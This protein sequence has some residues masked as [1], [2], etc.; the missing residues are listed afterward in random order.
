MRPTARCMHIG[1]LSDPNNFHTQKWARGLHQAG[2]EV[3]VF[4]F[5]PFSGDQLRHVRIDPPQAWRGRYTYLSYLRGGT[6]LAD[7][8]SEAGV[9]LL[10]PLNVTPF[11]VWAMQ[12]NFHPVVTCAFG[13]D[14]LEYPPAME[15]SP[16]LRHRS[17][18]NVEGGSSWLRRRKESVMRKFY[19]RQVRRALDYSD[20]VTGD[21]RYLVDRM[22]EWF[23]VPR[24]KLQLLRWGVEPELF[25]A[26]AR[27]LEA[28]RKKFGI[29]KDARVVLSPRG[30]KSI[31]QADIILAAFEQLITSGPA[32]VHYILLSAGYEVSERLR[33][34]AQ[35]LQQRSNRFVF[36]EEAVPREEIHTL[37]NLVDLFITA[38]VY[39]GYS[40]ALAEGRYAGAVPVV[41]AI[42]ANTELITHDHNGWIC[43]PFTA[44]QLAADLSHLLLHLHEFKE[45]Y[46]T[47]NRTWME[48][49]SLMHQNCGRFIEICKPLIPNG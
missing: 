46:Q 35:A 24:E 47:I 42:P 20:L 11:G 23:G 30:A 14:I 32:D 31:Y 1:I 38:P 40:A 9:D 29:P 3:T 19:R 25:T 37:W 43:D 21:N 39:D 26:D 4:S 22:H 18:S 27:Q 16:V 48:A 28:S 5:E 33:A 6:R 15:M 7:A 34:R 2:A 8:L 45:K 41:N 44:E 17:W 12:A 13:A 10:N 49:N 36:F